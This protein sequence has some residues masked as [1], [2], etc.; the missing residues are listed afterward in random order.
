S[1][2]AYRHI[3]A[4][5][6]S[7]A[8]GAEIRGVSV[9]RETDAQFAEIEDA[10]FRHKMIYLRGQRIGHGEHHA[11][12][13]RFGP[14][15]EDAYTAGV[16][17]FLEVQPLIKEADDRS[18]MVFGEGW[19]TDSPFLDEPPAITML[20]S[21]QIPPYGGDTIWANA[22]LALA[23]LSDTMRATI[24]DLRVHFSIRDVLAAAQANVEARDSPIGKFAAT[25]EL[26]V[27]PE[28]IQRKI[29]GNVHPLI[30]THARSGEQSLYLDTSYAVGFEGMRPEEAAPL[31]RFLGEH[32]TQPAFTCRLRWEP[33]MVVLWDN[34]LCLHQAFNDY[35]GYR[36]EMYRTTVAGEKPR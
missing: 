14:F 12:S 7:A 33:D 11:F 28:G 15:A 4:L 6:L 5:P 34:R 16:S 19:H 9:G 24:R 1:A 32:L 13:R 2:R 29:R 27:L 31:L 20:R 10:L 35:Q 3:E 18:E 30:R 23:M 17:G 25:R 36:R 8:M 21:V 22:A 26:S